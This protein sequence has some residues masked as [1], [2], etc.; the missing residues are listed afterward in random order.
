MYVDHE[1]ILDLC[2]DHF[3]ERKATGVLTAGSFQDLKI[4]YKAVTVDA[5]V[6]LEWSSR[7]LRKQVIPPSQLFHPS[8]VVGSPFLT[9]VSPGAAGYP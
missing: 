9:T 7:S 3:I 4:E 5:Y 1:L 6:Q 2:E 8:H